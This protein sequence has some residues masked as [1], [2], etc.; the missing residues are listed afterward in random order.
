MGGSMK[1]SIVSRS[2]SYKIKLVHETQ[3]SKHYM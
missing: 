2:K 3:D 1:Y